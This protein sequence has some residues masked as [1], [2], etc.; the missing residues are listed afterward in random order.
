MKAKKIALGL[1]ILGLNF[2][3]CSKN[4]DSV[5]IIESTPEYPMKTLIENGI[6]E[7]NNTKVN[8]PNT[9]ELGYKFKPFKNGKI[10]A[11]GVRVPENDTYRITLWNVDTEEILKTINVT[12][13]SGLLSFEDIDPINIESGTSY[14][15]SVNTNDYYSFNDGGNVIFPAE[16]DNILITGYGSY[17]GQ[18]QT[19]PVNFGNTAY[20]GMVDI[21]FIPN[22]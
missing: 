17:F 16:I 20:L 21:K 12:S 4:D 7:L 8:S 10:T 9:F 2:V 22:N 3:S 15:V 13:S 19:L 18:N 14:F 5:E 11:L 6:M 1:L